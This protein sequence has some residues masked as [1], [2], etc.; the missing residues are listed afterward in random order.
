[1]AVVG[2]GASAIQIVPAIAPRV[3]RLSVFQ[4]TPAWIVPKPDRPY[5]AREQRLFRAA[6]WLQRLARAAIYWRRELLVPAFTRHPWLLAL[7]GR[8]VRRSLRKKV[9]DP[10]LRQRLTPRDVMGCKRVLP[11]NDFYPALLRPNVELVDTPI[12]EVRPEGIA[13]TDGVVRPFDAIVYATGFEA[14]EASPPFAL[15]GRGG[16]RLED[17]WREGI[18]AYLGTSVAGFPNLFLIVGPNVGL[19]HSSMILMM[20][21]QFEYVLDALRTLHTQRL[22]SVEVRAQV[23]RRY[24]DALQARLARTVWNTGGCVSW[25]RT[26]SG[27]NTTLWPGST[28]GFRRRTRRFV[29]ADYLRVPAAPSE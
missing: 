29:A 15:V 12:S 2:T 20:E 5:T 18:E 10:A 4:R 28:Y 25:Y 22:A 13:T 6:P 7:A 8:V 21:A 3:A 26:R 14:A 23:Q 16:I 27:R 19:G 24:N 9:P 1:V 17:A 11:S